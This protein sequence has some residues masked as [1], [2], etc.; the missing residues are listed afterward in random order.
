MFKT[1]VFVK[2][3]PLGPHTVALKHNQSQQWRTPFNRSCKHLK[4]AQ[5]ITKR[6]S[7]PGFLQF[8]GKIRGFPSTTQKDG[9]GHEV[10]VMRYTH[11]HSRGACHSVSTGRSRNRP[12]RVGRTVAF[13]LLLGIRTLQTSLTP[14]MDII[15][16]TLQVRNGGWRWGRMQAYLCAFSAKDHVPLLARATQLPLSHLQ[17]TVIR[18][19]LLGS[20]EVHL[21]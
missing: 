2:G 11:A 3:E 6:C 21:I 7:S 9:W 13:V 18:V 20:Q 16:L 12:L 10:A 4:V 15:E 17:S 19:R 5:P 8:Q 1:I 14:Q